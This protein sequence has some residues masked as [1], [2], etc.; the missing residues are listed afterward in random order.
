MSDEY[1][2]KD[3]YAILGVNASAT[4]EDIKKAFLKKCKE[5]HPDTN[6]SDSASN[7]ID[8]NNAF[9]ILKD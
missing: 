3:Y 2:G 9:E 7:F 5:T 1:G 8:V 6:N 4:A